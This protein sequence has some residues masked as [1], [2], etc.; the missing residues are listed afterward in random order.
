[1]LLVQMLISVQAVN[2]STAATPGIVQRIRIL[3]GPGILAQLGEAFDTLAL[4]CRAPITARRPWLEAWIQSYREYRPVAVG[5]FEEDQALAAVALFAVRPRRLG[6]EVVGL[7]HGAS[8]QSRVY[9]VDDD[10]AEELARAVRSWLRLS[11]PRPWRL[12]LEQLPA[13]DGAVRALQRALPHHVVLPAPG[14]P[15]VLFT[16][17]RTPGRYLTANYRG[18][19]KNKWN[20]MVKDGLRPKIE[21][22]TSAEE[23]APILPPVMEIAGIRQEELTGHRKLDRPHHARFFT[24][25]VLEHARRGEVELMLL[26]IGG[27]IGAYSLTFR[28]GASARMWSSHYHPRWSAYSPGHIL[29]RALVEQCVERRDIDVLDWMKGLEPYKL[30]TAN[31][32]EPAQSLHAWSG[33]AGRIAGEAAEL[34]RTMLLRARARYPVLRRLQ[35]GLRQRLGR[36]RERGSEKAGNEP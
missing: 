10:A 36:I 30:R 20:R 28:D 8:D 13:D 12:T 11:L 16:A 17:D 29:S 7:G 26:H 14:S 24:A 31:H 19:A 4:R 23:I 2:R 1:V 32:V 6:T 15:M 35:I 3:E 22:L 25:V 21:I 34:L 18:Q 5:I 27:E 9:A 33:R